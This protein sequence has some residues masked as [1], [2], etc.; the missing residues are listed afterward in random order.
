MNREMKVRTSVLEAYNQLPE[1]F[2][3]AKSYN[4]YLEQLE[5]ISMC[6]KKNLF[7]KKCL[8]FVFI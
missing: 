7:L 3:D 2:Q 1:D 8:C 5:D 4:D 6:E